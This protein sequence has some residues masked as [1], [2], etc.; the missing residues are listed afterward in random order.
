MQYA[1]SPLP[2][3]RR[4]SSGMSFDVFGKPFGAELSF[5]DPAQCGRFDIEVF[6]DNP[7]GGIRYVARATSN[8]VIGHDIITRQSTL[9]SA[10]RISL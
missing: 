7:T 2:P 5:H 3:I 10:V 9:P 1:G 8:E 4:R 6:A